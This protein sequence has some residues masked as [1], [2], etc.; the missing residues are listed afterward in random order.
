MG[1]RDA[2]SVDFFTVILGLLTLIVWVANLL[3]FIQDCTNENI[4]M[5]ILHGVGVFSGFL[6]WIT[7]WF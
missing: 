7:V 2:D 3:K 5:A 6:C 1:S 4:G